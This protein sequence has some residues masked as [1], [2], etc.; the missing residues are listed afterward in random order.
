MAE[1]LMNHFFGDRY[2]ASSAGTEATRV[3]PFA[4][5]VLEEIGVD[6]SAHR[7]K[8][9][10]EFR[11]ERFD[12]VVTVC[13]SARES[14]PFFPGKRVI[15]RSFRDPSH[16]EGSDEELL[17]AFREVRDE[18]LAWLEEFSKERT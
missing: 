11:G 10:E 8:A 5:R 15:H 14:C 7:S 16:T 12:T 4:I 1:G 17:H 2:R 13:D 9:V 3:N 6:I 18:I